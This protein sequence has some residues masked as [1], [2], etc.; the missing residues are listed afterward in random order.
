MH[1]DVGFAMKVLSPPES[2]GSRRLR[3]AA[4]LSPNARVDMTEHSS[5]PTGNRLL[6]YLRDR[7]AAALLDCL[8]PVDLPLK[9]VL[10]EPDEVIPFIYFLDEG[11]ASVVAK[12]PEGLNI[13]AGFIGRE[14][15]VLP[16]VAL[17]ATTVPNLC[18]VQIA[19]HGHRIAVSEFREA[20]EDNRDLRDLCL[21]FAQTVI[22]QVAYTALSNAGPSNKRAARSLVAHVSRSFAERRYRAHA[23]VHGGHARDAPTDGDDGV[24]RA[25][26]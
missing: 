21:R 2:P 16:G 4:S 25:R 7:D 8:E 11:I 26:R 15:F 18:D 3:E 13:E 14:G 9:M 5:P 6:A 1:A 17:G 23:R 19:G 24:A 20:M 12:S 22:V 10:I